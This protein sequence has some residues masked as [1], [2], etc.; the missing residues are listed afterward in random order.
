MMIIVVV[1]LQPFMFTIDSGQEETEGREELSF[2]F[3][4]KGKLSCISQHLGRFKEY[5]R[6]L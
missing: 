6:K 1:L 3:F 4:L 5:P 2:T